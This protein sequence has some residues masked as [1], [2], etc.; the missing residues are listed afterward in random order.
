MFARGVLYRIVVLIL[1][2][3]SDETRP[4]SKPGTELYGVE[5]IPHQADKEVCRYV[6]EL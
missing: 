6:G 4:L 2:L 3:E 1:F 5:S